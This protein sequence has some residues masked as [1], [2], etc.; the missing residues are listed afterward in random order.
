MVAARG[1]HKNSKELVKVIVTHMT[2]DWLQL[3]TNERYDLEQNSLSILRMLAEDS[4]SAQQIAQDYPE[5]LQDSM[6][7]ILENTDNQVS[8][9]SS[10]S[11]I[12]HMQKAS[13]SVIVPVELQKFVKGFAQ[14]EIET[15]GQTETETLMHKKRS[16]QSQKLQKSYQNIQIN[17]KSKANLKGNISFDEF[18]S[19]DHNTP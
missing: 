11:L 3:T 1:V 13:S 15:Q 5:I 18:L 14:Q 2:Q 17:S 4:L 8:T 7:I 10:R 19:K 9:Y 16:L 6:Q 12:Y